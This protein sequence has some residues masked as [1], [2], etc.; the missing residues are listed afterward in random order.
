MWE[1]IAAIVGLL[2][3]INYLFMTNPS[4]NTTTSQMGGARK[5][6]MSYKHHRR[7]K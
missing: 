5:H 6:K 1:L 4:N 3:A 7:H 2:I